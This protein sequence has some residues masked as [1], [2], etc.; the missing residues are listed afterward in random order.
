MDSE[1]EGIDRQSSS[2]ANLGSRLLD[3][4]PRAPSI[5]HLLPGSKG[6]EEEGRSE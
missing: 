2:E 3:Y 4:I 1:E 5:D 6:S